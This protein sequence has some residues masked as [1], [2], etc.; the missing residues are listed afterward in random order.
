M[1]IRSFKYTAENQKGENIKGKMEAINREICHKFIE[2]KNYKVIEIREYNNIITAL[3]NITIGSLIKQ[4][5]LI[6]FLKQLGSLLT[7]GVPLLSALELLSLQ[8]EKR[9]LRRLYFELYHEV[10]NGYSFSNALSKR[11]KEFPKLL[12]QMVQV[13]ELSG[14]LD[15]MVIQMAE[16]YDKQLKI[17]NGIKGAIR[18]PAIYLIATLLIAAGMLLFVFPNI[19]D[20][21]SSFGDAELPAITQFFLDTGSFFEKYIL[22]IAIVILGVVSTVFLLDRY[23]KKTHLFFTKAI[24]KL[25][26]IGKLIQMHNQIM[27]A[28]A[29]SQ[30]LA[31][32]V[33]SLDA[34]KIIKTFIKNTVYKKIILKTIAYIEDGRPFSRA[35]EESNYIDPIMAKMIATG[36]KT[37]DVP[38][39]MKNLSKYYNGISD[40]RVEQLKNALQP[41]LLLFVY[42]IVGVMILAIMLPMISLG[43]QI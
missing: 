12:V 20:L 41:I 2:S 38:N 25:P 1:K 19:T 24:L 30:M 34:L 35:F 13:G 36:E 14:D 39:L 29:L 40:L 15:N 8:N 17:S 18:M 27:I 37:S 9:N 5:D 22:A 3:N 6:F 32:G 10:Y 23:H 42:S 7:S 33:N 26:V 31:N 4:K 16:Y 43:G 28:N 11:P 21:F